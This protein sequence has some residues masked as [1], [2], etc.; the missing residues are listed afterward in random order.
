MMG[1]IPSHAVDEDRGESELERAVSEQD[2]SEILQSHH[3]F[4]LAG[5]WEGRCGGRRR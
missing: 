4:C 2:M 5:S 3:P 1:N